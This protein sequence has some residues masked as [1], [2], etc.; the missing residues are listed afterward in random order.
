MADPQNIA[1][2]FQLTLAGISIVFAVLAFIAIFVAIIQQVDRRWQAREE[3]QKK[4]ASEKDPTI[5]NTTLVLISAAV[6]TVIAGRYRIRRVKR[7]A[8]AGSKWSLQGRGQI[9]GSHVLNKHL[10]G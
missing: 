9:H 4:E 2:G 5:D 8:S 1:F 10:K 6:A 7:V 3:K